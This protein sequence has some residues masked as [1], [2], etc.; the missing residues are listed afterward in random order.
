[1]D[2]ERNEKQISTEYGISD[3]ALRFYIDLINDAVDKIADIL[4]DD[5]DGLAYLNSLQNSI[6]LI[7]LYFDGYIK[8]RDD[9]SDSDKS[10]AQN[11]KNT[12]G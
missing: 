7:E 12:D 1:M 5:I 3:D 2:S 4:V 11:L 9:K 10:C 6:V 8:P